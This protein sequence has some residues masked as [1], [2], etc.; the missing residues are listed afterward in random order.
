MDEWVAIYKFGRLALL[1]LVLCGIAFH[2]YRPGN[3]DRYEAPARRMLEE[4]DA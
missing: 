4:D 1:G 3:R 2:L